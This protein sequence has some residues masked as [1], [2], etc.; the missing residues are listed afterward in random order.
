MQ[1]ATH[2]N[3]FC[4]EHT[5]CP[6]HTHFYKHRCTCMHCANMHVCT[7]AQAHAYYRSRCC[8]V[9][10]QRLAVCVHYTMWCGSFWKHCCLHAVGQQLTCRQCFRTMA[11]ACLKQPRQGNIDM[12][13]VKATTLPRRWEPGAKW[14]V[15]H[16]ELRLHA[17]C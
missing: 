3:V 16:A 13:A 1:D 11:D 5:L 15:N 4:P 14:C 17:H 12:Y 8:R 10:K 9:A 6:Q 7:A 2:S